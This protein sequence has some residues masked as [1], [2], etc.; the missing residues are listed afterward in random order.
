MRGGT[1]LQILDE[2]LSIL[3]TVKPFIQ[4]YLS[5][6][7]ASP[8]HAHQPA[9]LDS[10]AGTVDIAWLTTVLLAV[11]DRVAPETAVTVD[12]DFELELDDTIV[13]DLAADESELHCC[14]NSVA[15]SSNDRAYAPPHTVESEASP[16][17]IVLQF[18]EVVLRPRNY[19]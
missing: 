15:N 19:P 16:G 10:G 5:N 13:V 12:C 7:V 17:Q 8:G 6:L 4:R 3:D 1:L 18:V 2:R 11:D 9:V 14:R